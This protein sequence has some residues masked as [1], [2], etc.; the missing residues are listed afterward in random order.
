MFSNKNGKDV[1][2]E[3]VFATTSEAEAKGDGRGMN[4]DDGLG[5]KTATYANPLPFQV[6]NDPTVLDYEYHIEE[7]ENSTRPGCTTYT[8]TVKWTVKTAR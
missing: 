8:A 7:D 3:S 2:Q 5:N 1:E 4:D 6:V